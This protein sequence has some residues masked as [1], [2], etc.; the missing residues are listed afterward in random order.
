MTHILGRLV[1][2]DIPGFIS[3]LKFQCTLS[4]PLK[5][6]MHYFSDVGTVAHNC[7]G[8]NKSFTAK[9]NRSQQKKIA[10]GKKKS[11]TAKAN[12]SRR[13]QIVHGKRKSLTARATLSNSRPG[14]KFTP[15]GNMEHV[16]DGGHS[17]FFHVHLVMPSR[18]FARIVAQKFWET[19]QRTSVHNVVQVSKVFSFTCTARWPS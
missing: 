19:M 13:K 2:F 11:L 16:Q 3:F 12:R 10:H 5:R 1:S 15:Q 8:K 7:H 4:Q 14:Y 17:C 6:K 18:C 9:E